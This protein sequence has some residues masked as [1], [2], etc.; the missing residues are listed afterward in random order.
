MSAS[1]GQPWTSGAVVSVAS[2][3]ESKMTR[4][5]SRC[6]AESS[7]NVAGMV[8]GASV[9]RHVNSACDAVAVAPAGAAPAASRQNAGAEAAVEGGRSRAKP[10]WM[11]GCRKLSG[12]CCWRS[13]NR[14]TRRASTVSCS[15]PRVGCVGKMVSWSRRSRHGERRRRR[16]RASALNA[17]VAAFFG[18]TVDS[19]A[20]ADFV[21]GG[22]DEVEATAAGRR[23]NERSVPGSDD[24]AGDVTAAS[25]ISEGTTAA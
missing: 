6:W 17:G 14:R 9:G 2:P 1:H 15:A 18:S 21:S 19:E 23:S 3:L 10:R 7:V 24:E 8:V 22:V 11:S 16:W 20:V 5:S 25:D 12:I 13:R 4:A